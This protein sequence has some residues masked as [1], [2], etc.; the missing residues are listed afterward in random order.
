MLCT[1][2]AV[3]CDSDAATIDVGIP[4]ATSS[5]CEGPDNTATPLGFLSSSLITCES[6]SSVPF[7][8]PFE[9]FTTIP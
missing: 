2:S 8:S 6:R 3:V 7:S 1:I 9:T 4:R 5:A